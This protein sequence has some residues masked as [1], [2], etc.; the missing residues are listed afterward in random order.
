MGLTSLHDSYGSWH[1]YICRFLFGLSTFFVASLLFMTGFFGPDCAEMAP[2]RAETDFGQQGWID[3]LGLKQIFSIFSAVI[4]KLKSK[5]L[6][7]R[8]KYIQSIIKMLIEIVAKTLKYLHRNNTHKKLK[9]IAAW[10]NN[11]KTQSNKLR[12]DRVTLFVQFWFKFANKKHLKNQAVKF[13]L[14]LL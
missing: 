2:R 12:A 11:K 10:M 3:T 5:N 8:L 1:L 7:M 4:L 9:E 13:T 14:T 6:C